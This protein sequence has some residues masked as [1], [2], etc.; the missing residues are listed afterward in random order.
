VKSAE[1]VNMV[2]NLMSCAE[3]F[4]NEEILSFIKNFDFSAGYDKIYKKALEL[5]RLLKGGKR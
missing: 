2:N 1:L 4:K 5:R 3:R